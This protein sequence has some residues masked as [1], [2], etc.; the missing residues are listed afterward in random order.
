MENNNEKNNNEKNN[1]EII[2]YENLKRNNYAKEIRKKIQKIEGNYKYS[3]FLTEEKKNY[4]KSLDITKK[5]EELD[6]NIQKKIYF[7]SMRN[8]WK[9]ITLTTIYRPFWY[10]YKEYL[11]KEKWK[12]YSKNIHFMHLEF[13]TLPENKKYIMGCQCEFC[14]DYFLQNVGNIKFCLTEKEF[15]CDNLKLS[16]YHDFNKNYWNYYLVN[17]LKIYDHLYE[18]INENGYIDLSS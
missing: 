17:G 16:E 11:D 2:Y 9:K 7:I 13:N 3:Q 15:I 1:N 6:E 10:S 4:I 8:Y 18:L 5:I 12:V 14:K